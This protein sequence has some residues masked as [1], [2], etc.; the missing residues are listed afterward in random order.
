MLFYR[1]L[2]PY[3]KYSLPCLELQP[4]EFEIWK[5]LE[6]APPDSFDNHVE[7]LKSLDFSLL[8]N[9]SRAFLG[10]KEDD[11]QSFIKKTDTTVIERRSVITCMKPLYKNSADPKATTCL[12]VAAECGDLYILD[13]SAFTIL[14]QAKVCSSPMAPVDISASGNFDVDFNIVIYTREQT[15]CI[16]KKGWLEGQQIAQVENPITGLALL[17]IEQTII[18]VCTDQCLM[19]FSKRGKRMWSANLPEKAICLTPMTLSHLGITLV[20]VALQSGKVQIYLQKNLVDEFTV[21]ATVTAM[22]FGRLG[23]EDHVLA[24]I[25]TSK[26]KL[27]DNLLVTIFSF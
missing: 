12:I 14:Q 11:R 19:C 5:Q 7:A 9:L 27:I 21:A 24:L 1:N 25:T 17:P 13:S 23:Q 16:L 2:K 3:Y 6:L 18:V 4:L 20:C 26:L 15:V 8:S 22:I 10:C